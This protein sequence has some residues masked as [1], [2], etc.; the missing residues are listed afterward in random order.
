MAKIGYYDAYGYQSGE[1]FCK[2]F[3]K[4]TGLDNLPDTIQKGVKGLN[5]FKNIT[6]IAGYIPGVGT[7]VALFKLIIFKLMPGQLEKKAKNMPENQK[8]AVMKGV[9]VLKN[10]FAKGMNIRILFELF[11]LG[12]LLIITD[13]ISTMGNSKSKE[14][15]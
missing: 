6:Q 7:I 12:S 1:T 4:A 9:N 3:N 14:K 13:F 8:N 11:S 5:T 15:A 2:K 10:D